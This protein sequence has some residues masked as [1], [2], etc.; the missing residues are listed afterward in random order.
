MRLIRANYS[1]LFFNILAESNAMTSYVL[2]IGFHHKLGTT[3]EYVYPELE[4]GLDLP[5]QWSYIPPTALPDG[6]HNFERGLSFL[7]SNI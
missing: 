6:A 1:F 2:I 7:L 4:T 5:P 3:V